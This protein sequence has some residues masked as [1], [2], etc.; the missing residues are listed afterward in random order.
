MCECMMEGVRGEVRG[1]RCL[2]M[3]G[4]THEMK[5]LA[6]SVCVETAQP[7][8]LSVPPCWSWL[9]IRQARTCN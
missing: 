7:L 6:S 4:A 8:P 2:G 5:L 9:A 3:L 1:R